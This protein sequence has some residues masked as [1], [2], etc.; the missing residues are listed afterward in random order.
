MI[1]VSFPAVVR[2]ST[3]DFVFC[4]TASASALVHKL[5]FDY[6]KVN[7]VLWLSWCFPILLLFLLI[8]ATWCLVRQKSEMEALEDENTSKKFYNEIPKFSSMWT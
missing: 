2:K 6:H 7:F 5:I 3:V 4:L 8:L 1:N